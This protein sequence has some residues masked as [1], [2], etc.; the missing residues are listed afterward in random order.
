MKALTH[1]SPYQPRQAGSYASSATYHPNGSLAGLNYGNGMIHS[2]T[3]NTRGLPS[4]IRDRKGSLSRLDYA[5]GYDKNGNV[6][7]I[8]DYTSPPYWNESRYLAYDA[9]DRM[10]QATAPNIFDGELYNYD[11]LDNVRRMGVFPNGLG[12]YLQ[13][14]Y[15][16][17][18]TSNQRLDRINE[19][20]G[21][22]EWDF[23]H[24]DLGETTS[25]TSSYLGATWNYQWNAA[26]RMVRAERTAPGNRVAYPLM[27]IAELSSRFASWLSPDGLR[28][29]A[30]SA[31]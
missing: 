6:T 24:N 23:D 29:N 2:R 19:A 16:T 28:Q 9:R 25:R 30:P 26:G 27:P 8:V 11:P 31:V 5:Y 3:L 15:Y 7:S 10:T 21:S 13:D 18:S 12:G 17:Y 14:Y 4:R 22:L 1:A 20:N